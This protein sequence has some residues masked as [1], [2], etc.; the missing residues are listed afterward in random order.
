[1]TFSSVNLSRQLGRCLWRW[2]WKLSGLAGRIATSSPVIGLGLA[3]YGLATHYVDAM[4]Q[5]TPLKVTGWFDLK[6]QIGNVFYAAAH[7]ATQLG[8]HLWHGAWSAAVTNLTTMAGI[9]SDLYTQVFYAGATNQAEAFVL[10]A[11]PFLGALVVGRLPFLWRRPTGRPGSPAAPALGGVLAYLA[12]IGMV[13]AATTTLLLNSIT[14]YQSLAGLAGWLGWLGSGLSQVIDTVISVGAGILKEV[15]WHVVF[16][17]TDGKEKTI[18]LLT[19][20]QP[21]EDLAHYLGHFPP[22]KIPAAFNTVAYQALAAGLLLGGA[23][24]WQH[25]AHTRGEPVPVTRRGRR[26]AEKPRRPLPSRRRTEPRSH[27]A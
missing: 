2:V 10:F 27:R 15:V 23:L 17:L 12:R 8:P 11:P 25:R 19:R 24:H 4:R 22:D 26:R 9:R 14:T 3:L 16:M 18:G 13:S 6:A 5:H 7:N 20:N 21:V 1:M